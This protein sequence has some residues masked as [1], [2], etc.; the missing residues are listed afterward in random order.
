MNSVSSSA[1]SLAALIK[2]LQDA[3]VEND[4][5]YAY[6][7]SVDGALLSN[8]IATFRAIDAETPPAGQSRHETK[9]WSSAKHQR[10]GLAFE[11]ILGTLLM[12]GGR[13]FTSWQRLQTDT[14]EIDYLV[15][16][17]PKSGIIPVLREWGTHF[18]C[19]CKSTEAFSTTWLE[20]LFAILNFNAAKVGLVLSKKRPS[21]HGNG[22]RAHST[23]LRSAILGRILLTFD[24]ED[25]ESCAN[26]TNFLLLLRDRYIEVRTG[27]NEL[28]L[29]TGT[30]QGSQQTG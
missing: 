5:I 21:K 1:D 30:Q 14:N 12:P 24:L 20:K 29:I 3:P 27:V 17:E 10:K 25:V 8:Q 18:I 15:A 16:L 9:Q 13:C 22:A 4:A 7:S 23:I 19:E 2:A 6:L 11:A 26:G 28:R